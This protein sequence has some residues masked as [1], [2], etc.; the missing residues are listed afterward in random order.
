MNFPK[1]IQTF[2]DNRDEVKRLINIHTKVAGTAP[3]RKNNESQVLN[4]SAVVLLV[5]CWESYIETIVSDAFDFML[6]NAVSYD[7]FPST[8]LTKAAKELRNDKDERK[9]WLIADRG[10]RKILTKYKEST[11]KKE[12][13]YFHV[14]RPTNID[15]LF[16][17]LIGFDNLSKTWTWKGQT[18][19]DTISTLN[20]LIDLRG[21]I[22]HKIKVDDSIGKR[23]VLY[24]LNFINNLT[25]A[26]NNAV[27]KHVEKRVGQKPW[28]TMKYKVQRKF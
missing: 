4:K 2:I 27:T 13:D 17:K 12:I 25:V 22:A 11:F 6:T 10:W 3:A 21:N 19:S 18:N 14:P 16:D 26:T 23:D 1:H 9:I 8:V 20:K 7:V 28:E 15:G 5:A 24:Y